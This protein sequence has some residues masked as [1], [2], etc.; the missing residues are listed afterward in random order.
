MYVVEESTHQKLQ[1]AHKQIISAQQ[2]VLD[3]QGANNKLI[4][5]AEQQLIQAEQA[6][7]ALQTN[8]GT[9]LTENPQFQQAYEELHDIRQ[10]VQEADRKSVV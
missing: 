3:A 9:E 1:Q 4:E 7:Q 8:E 5:Q 10:Q 2:A 6:L